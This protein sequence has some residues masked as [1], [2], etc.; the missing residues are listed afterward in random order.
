MKG[1]KGG[2]M[3][4]RNERVNDGKSKDTV[5]GRSGRKRGKD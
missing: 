4:K 5:Q 1:G 3:E 2:K